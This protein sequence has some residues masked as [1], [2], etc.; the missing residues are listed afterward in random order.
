MR[1]ISIPTERFRSQNRIFHEFYDE[2]RKIGVDAGDFSLAKLLDPKLGILQVHFPEHF[3]TNYPMPAALART[4][5]LLGAVLLCKARGVPVVW[6]V[7]NID[8]FEDTNARLCRLHMSLF[9]AL[10]DACIFLSRSSEAKFHDRYPFARPSRAMHILHP[11]YNVALAPLPTSQPIVLG[12]IGEQKHYKQPLESLRIFRAAASSVNARL[13]IAGEVHDADTFRAHLERDGSSEFEWL[14]R[15]VTDAEMESAAKR[16]HFV[17]LPYSMITNSGAAMFALSC[18]RPIVCSDQP[19][20][21]E[22]QGMFGAR[23][24]RIADGRETQADFWA[25]PSVAD[26]SALRE[27]LN[28]L[29]CAAIAAKHKDFFLSLRPGASER[30]RRSRGKVFARAHLA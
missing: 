7:H 19:L 29:S 14:E 20:F 22:L 16:C 13:L 28:A 4:S 8:I 18:G 3:A 23:W 25:L 21:R 11:T 27:K 24:I 30:K 12:M 26:V 5:I 17:L 15:R 2:L 10:V 1:I 9:A 6:T